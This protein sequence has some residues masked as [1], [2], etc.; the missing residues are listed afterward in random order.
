MNKHGDGSARP[1]PADWLLPDWPAPP[2]VQA[3]CSM[4]SGGVSQ[5]PFDTLNLGAHVGDAAAAVQV[6]RRILQSALQARTPAARAVFLDQR[7]GAAVAQLDQRSADGTQ[8]DACLSRSAGLV[9]T[10]LV[11]DCLP[12]LLAH[13]SGAVVAAAHAGWRGLAGTRGQG[14]L[15]AVFR[16]FCALLRQSPA[17]VAAETLAWLGPCIGPRAFEVGAEVRAAFCTDADT[18]AAQA[19]FAA[20]GQASG[21]YLCDLAALA[22]LRLSALGVSRVYGNDGSAPWCT[23]GNASRF[24]SHRRDAATLGGSGRFAACIWRD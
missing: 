22:R 9:C 11:A 10:I 17:A 23:V 1:L 5:Q 14:V 21:K 18:A 6:N 15:E 13:R 16:H 8:A 3:L 19:C 4:R 20:H 24:F 2:G 7:H 12:V